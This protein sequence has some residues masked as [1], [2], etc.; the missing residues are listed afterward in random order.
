MADPADAPASDPALEEDEKAVS[1]RTEEPDAPAAEP[2][3]EEEDASAGAG[4]GEGGSEEPSAKDS[5]EEDDEGPD[6]YEQV[7]FDSIRVVKEGEG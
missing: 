1:Q 2:G 3:T 7:G 5:S 4:A 6:E